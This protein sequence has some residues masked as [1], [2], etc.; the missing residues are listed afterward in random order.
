MLKEGRDA[1]GRDAAVSMVPNPFELN[2]ILTLSYTIRA[3][4]SVNSCSKA[5]RS[6]W[7]GACCF[8]AGLEPA[9]NNC[10]DCFTLCLT[11]QGFEIPHK[12][13]LHIET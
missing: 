13:D 2:R 9:Q 11:V 5:K 12:R 7:R 3:D 8:S 6:G 4:S 10:V 1:E